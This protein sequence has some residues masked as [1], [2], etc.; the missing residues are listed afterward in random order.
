LEGETGT[1]KAKSGESTMKR[2]VPL[3]SNTPPRGSADAKMRGSR[4]EKTGKEETT[5][6]GRNERCRNRPRAI[7]CTGPPGHEDSLPTD[8][9]GLR[10]KKKRGKKG[11]TCRQKTKT[12]CASLR[13]YQNPPHKK[14]QNPT[15]IKRRKSVRNFERHTEKQ[16]KMKR[17]REKKRP[18]CPRKYVQATGTRNWKIQRY[19]KAGGGQGGKKKGG[20]PV[21]QRHQRPALNPQRERPEK[22]T[23]H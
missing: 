10:R 2:D 8:W 14:P 18:S 5:S 7:N 6:G 12:G 21:Q 23:K 3:R 9:R 4:Q 19:R 1:K 20:K 17:E 13:I 11:V 16:E 22:Q 15:T